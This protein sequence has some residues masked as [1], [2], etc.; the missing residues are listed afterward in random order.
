MTELS[1]S[2]CNLGEIMFKDCE[3]FESQ[4][5]PLKY[6]PHRS[7]FSLGAGSNPQVHIVT[8]ACSLQY[9][10]LFVRLTV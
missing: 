6:Q 8:C 9:V 3:N 2:R 1:D 4:R 7:V 5:K 10:M